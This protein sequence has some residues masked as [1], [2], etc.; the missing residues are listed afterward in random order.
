M[1]TSA[2]VLRTAVISAMCGSMA[3]V[4]GKI[5][6][7]TSPG[8]VLERNNLD[9]VVLRGILAASIL[10]L[11]SAMLSLYV[12]VLQRVSALQ[13]SLLAFVCNYLISTIFGIFLFRE[14]ISY[15]WLIGAILMITGAFRASSGVNSVGNK[16]VI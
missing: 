3:S 8:N 6:F 14:A 4:C 7:D 12:K 11:N 16:K 2:G 1:T 9:H 5:A 15:Q 13:A 10:L